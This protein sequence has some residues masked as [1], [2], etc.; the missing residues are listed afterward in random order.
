M[1]ISDW[2]SHVCSSDLL[3]KGVLN[4]DT[5]EKL[6]SFQFAQRATIASNE[7]KLSKEKRDLMEKL[8][9]INRNRAELTRGSGKTVREA[10]VFAN[11]PEKRSVERRVGTECVRTGG[12]RWSPQ[13]KKK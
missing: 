12:S 1:R 3:T 6:T 5:I 8:D 10:V 13:H 11:L 9:T 4:A 7:L 2:S